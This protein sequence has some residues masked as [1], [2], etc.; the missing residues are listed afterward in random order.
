MSTCAEWPNGKKTCVYLRPNLTSTKVNASPRKSSQVNASGWPN[1][2]QVN[3]I[4]QNYGNWIFQPFSI[5]FPQYFHAMERGSPIFAVDTLSHS[6]LII[7]YNINI[8][9]SL[10]GCNY[11]VPRNFCKPVHRLHIL[12]AF[13]LVVGH[14][15]LEQHRI[16]SELCS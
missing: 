7:I 6:T 4:G 12:K 11:F 15:C 5:I 2:T 9:L 10:H 3:G 13:G 1:E 8:L 16:C 14:P